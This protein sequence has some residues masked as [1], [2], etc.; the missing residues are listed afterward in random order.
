MDL[1]ASMRVFL[2]A[3]FVSLVAGCVQMQSLRDDIVVIGDSVL[4]WNHAE[5]GDVGSVIGIELVRTVVN[6][7]A[8][9]AQIRA[10]S[11]AGLLGLSIPAQLPP[12]PAC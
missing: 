2:V 1:R 5:G 11:F 4:A 9:G 8:F 7:A 12:D 6:R 3:F 10:N